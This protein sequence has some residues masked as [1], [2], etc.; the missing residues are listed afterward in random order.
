MNLYA[1]AKIICCCAE[2]GYAEQS[3]EA[4]KVCVAGIHHCVSHG[5]QLMAVQLMTSEY[6]SVYGY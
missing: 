5:L 1:K 6:F 3:A 4:D 2:I